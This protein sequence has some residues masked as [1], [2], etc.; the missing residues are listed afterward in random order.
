MKKKITLCKIEE[1][2]CPYCGSEASLADYDACGFEGDMLYYP[3][4]CPD[5]GHSYQEWYSLKFIG[6]NVGDDF[7]TVTCAGEEGV[8]VEVE[9]E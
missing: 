6:H 3:V 2:I 1:G 4:R 8:V 7:D 9:E 5:C